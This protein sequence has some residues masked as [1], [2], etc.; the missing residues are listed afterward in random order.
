M[1]IEI[2]VPD[3]VTGQ[4]LTYKRD[5][6]MR[7][8]IINR[9]DLAGEACVVAGQYVEA[10]RLERACRGAAERAATA[11]AQWKADIATK[12]R[13]EAE[14]PTD[15]KA[16]AAYRTHPDYEAKAGLGTYYEQLAE[17]FGDVKR[18]F[19]IKSRQIGNLFDGQRRHIGVEARGAGVGV[20]V[21]DEP[22]L[23]E[24]EDFAAR[25]IEQ[26]RQKA[27]PVP[28]ASPPPAPEPEQE[29][30]PAKPRRSRA[31]AAPAAAPPPP[32][33]PEDDEPE[34]ED[35]E[36]EEP[37]PPPP[38]RAKGSKAAP[39]PDEPEEDDDVDLLDEEEDEPPP[40]RRKAGTK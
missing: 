21:E 10:A 4:D 6:V 32:P 15:K 30:Q 18:A 8:L 23:E 19:D 36:E 33:E 17:L 34:L 28:V 11:Y 3:A 40:R 24:L 35:E 1:P 9:A 2:T 27:V 38:R 5:D 29:A 16:E 20:P 37:P 22:S 39:P 13:A 31:V 14:K 7:A 26:T 25:A 12:Y